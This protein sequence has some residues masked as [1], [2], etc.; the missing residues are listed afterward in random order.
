MKPLEP[1]RFLPPLPRRA[2]GRLSFEVGEGRRHGRVVS[3]DHLIRG[4]LA[5]QGVKQRHRLGGSE[6]EIE[7]R[8]PLSLGRLAVHEALA[9]RRVVA[10]EDGSELF[11]ADLALELEVLGAPREPVA[12]C[13]AR[14]CVVIL[15]AAG[16]GVQVVELAALAELPDVEDLGPPLRT[17]VSRGRENLIRRQKR[18]TA[19]LLFPY[20]AP[21]GASLCSSITSSRAA[22]S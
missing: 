21:K 7:T 13:L 9:G 19:T 4:L 11:L 8:H 6:G 2:F 16:N 12:G 15:D 22:R 1:M 10:V 17:I 5:A 3:R 14:A 18:I 20:F